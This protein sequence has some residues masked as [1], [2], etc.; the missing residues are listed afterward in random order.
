MKV[1]ALAEALMESR[2]SDGAISRRDLEVRLSRA[3]LEELA[4]AV[5]S[6]WR[7][8]GVHREVAL[9]GKDHPWM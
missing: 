5:A 7:R 9:D 4:R 2:R 3:G 8:A 6:L 1:T